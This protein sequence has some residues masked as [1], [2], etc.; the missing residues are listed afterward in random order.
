MLDSLWRPRGN[1]CAVLQ[2][3]KV[4]L[5]GQR[6]LLRGGMCTRFLEKVAPP[7][8]GVRIVWRK[9]L[10]TLKKSVNTCVGKALWGSMSGKGGGEKAR[11]FY[12]PCP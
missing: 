8:G 6:K 4:P 12:G 2:N 10:E 1:T 3:E 5:G 9:G 7:R 11:F